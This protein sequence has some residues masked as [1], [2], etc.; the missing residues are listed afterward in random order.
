MTRNLHVLNPEEIMPHLCAGNPDPASC[1]ALIAAAG[2]GSRLKSDQPK[3]LY[4][5]AGVSMLERLLKLLS[6]F[7]ARFVLVV[8]PA[9]RTAITAETG[10]LLPG[11]CEIAEQAAPTGM[12][13]AV[14][15]GLALVTT[16][17]VL[18]VWG[19][20]A[21]LRPVSIR[22]SLALHYGPLAPDA[23]VPT[24]ICS[25]PYIHFERDQSGAI[26]QVLQAREGDLLPARGESDCGVFVFR[27]DALRLAL[28]TADASVGQMTG[29]RNFLPVLPALSR[30]GD[31][32]SVRIATKVDALG[33]N[34]REDAEALS[35]H[36]R[37]NREVGP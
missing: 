35:R 30:L 31:V 28:D 12:F 33:V 24:L 11:R 19:D 3:I 20:Q 23:T 37:Q 14:A 7:C 27:T 25:A 18:V 10:N 32:L 21:G 16:P 4:P 29:E 8:S 13:D 6:P 34:T 26:E 5:V 1:T 17:N 22:T 15:C 9:G 36:L 2:R